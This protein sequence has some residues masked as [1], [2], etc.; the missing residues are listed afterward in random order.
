MEKKQVEEIIEKAVV[1]GE[2]TAGAPLTG[3]LQDD[4][5]K[6]LEAA[7][8]QGKPAY[9]AM[10]I[11]EGEM[12]MMYGHAYNLHN[13]GNY[14]AASKI[15]QALS[16][17][18]N[19][20]ARYPLGLAASLHKMEDYGGAIAAYDQAAKNDDKDPYPLYHM[21]DCFEQLEN[22]IFSLISL[23]RAIDRIDE[24]NDPKHAAL[25]E[26]MLLRRKT[27][28]KEMDIDAE[29]LRNVEKQNEPGG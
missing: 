24:N 8:I 9:E 7:L 15:F 3:G 1:Q 5:K 23:G 14:T 2:E 12:E 22:P 11:D 27:L 6:V 20:S 16:L 29:E 10:Q 26:Q 28:C 4:I 18:D 21:S 25:K 19:D 17:L 13:S